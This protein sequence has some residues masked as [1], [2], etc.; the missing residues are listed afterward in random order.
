MVLIA[1]IISQFILCSLQCAFEEENC[2]CSQF[3]QGKK[4]P[5]GLELVS[6][7]SQGVNPGSLKTQTNSVVCW[8]SVS[9][10]TSVC[11]ISCQTLKQQKLA[12]PSLAAATPALSIDLVIRH[13]LFS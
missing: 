2:K 6:P 5:G 12:D 10:S 4:G 11:E 8:A 9:L 3:S 1:I 7:M 13:Q